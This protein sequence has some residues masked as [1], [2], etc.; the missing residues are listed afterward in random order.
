MISTVLSEQIETKEFKTGDS[1]A[2]NSK[3]KDKKLEKDAFEKI[4]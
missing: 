3:A 4:Y 1:Q 2:L